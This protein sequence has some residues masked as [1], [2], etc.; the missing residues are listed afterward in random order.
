MKNGRRGA[1]HRRDK[2]A[3]DHDI[4]EPIWIYGQHP[5]HAAL[6]NPARARLRLIATRNAARE[7]PHDA[8]PE[9]LEPAA[10]D[11][12]LPQGAVHQGVALLAEPLIQPALGE[13]LER[14]GTLVF[15]D[16]VTDP[17]NVGAILRSAAAFGAAGVVTTLRHAPPV[18][19]VL[20]KAASGAL[21]HVPYCQVTNLAEALRAARDAGW[22]VLGLDE[23]GEPLESIAPGSRTAIVL[24]AEGTGLR[25][26]TRKLCD[27][28]V[29]L[30]TNGPI[31]SLNVS[32]AAA[33]A[34]YALMR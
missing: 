19:S 1:H 26:L 11:K 20:A 28:I 12:L 9:I 8:A 13:I 6:V 14:E 25:E 17:H 7:L 2:R 10:I 16:Q 27:Q 34:L 5:V 4:G 24:G 32:N 30:R 33:V 22:L 15:L 23:A 18:T 3:S 31:G 21:E 29:R